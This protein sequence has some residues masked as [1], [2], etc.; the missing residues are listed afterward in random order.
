MTLTAEFTKGAA[1]AIAQS[2]DNQVGIVKKLVRNGQVLIL[3]DGK[4]YTVMGI[5]VKE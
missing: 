4:I 5:E 2:I 3:R 1:T